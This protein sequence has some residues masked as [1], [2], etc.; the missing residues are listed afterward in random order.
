MTGVIATDIQKSVDTINYDILNKSSGWLVFLMILLNNS[1]FIYVF[2]KPR[3]FLLRKLQSI[4]QWMTR[5]YSWFFSIL[6]CFNYMPV[7]FDLV[8]HASNSCLFFR[9]KN[10]RDF[11]MQLNEDFWNVGDWFVGNKLSDFFGVDETKS[12]L[13]VSNH[14]TKK[15]P[16]FDIICDNIKIK[17]LLWSIYLYCVL[18]ET[19][20]N[21]SMVHK[22]IRKVSSRLKFSH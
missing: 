12:I 9:R 19:K 17:Q 15:I 8:L 3:E 16:T 6:I 21:E 13:F 1:T 10:V 4:M 11:G 22:V 18:K 14:K 7:K 5:I 20:S 2:R